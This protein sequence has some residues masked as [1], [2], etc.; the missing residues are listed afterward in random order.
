MYVLCV[1][2]WHIFVVELFKTYDK[3]DVLKSQ[4]TKS[5]GDLATTFDIFCS[6][7]NFVHESY[8]I[9]FMDPF[10]R[11]LR[12]SLGFARLLCCTSQNF[13]CGLRPSLRMT[14]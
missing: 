3:S 5:F 6:K 11:T 13:D 14:R 1:I 10:G 8:C 4:R 7:C 9:S 2:L 12:G